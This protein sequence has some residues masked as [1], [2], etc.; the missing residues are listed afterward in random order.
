VDNY[1]V[2][3]SG[4]RLGVN[5]GRVKFERD[6]G[7]FGWIGRHSC[8]T[9][10]IWPAV[11]R[12]LLHRRILRTSAT[13]VQPQEGVARRGFKNNQWAAAAAAA[14]TSSAR[15]AI[16]YNNIIYAHDLRMNA[17]A[18]RTLVDGVSGAVQFSTAA[19]DVYK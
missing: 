17:S 9:T 13:V 19:V 4:F 10:S 16:I 7:R 8:H 1:C 12:L 3:Q 2:S 5:G 11:G 14:A 15:N 18:K 6:A